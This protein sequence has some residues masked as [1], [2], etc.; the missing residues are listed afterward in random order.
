MII[1]THFLVKT[2]LQQPEMSSYGPQV[3]QNSIQPGSEQF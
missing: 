1:L 2:P 3:A